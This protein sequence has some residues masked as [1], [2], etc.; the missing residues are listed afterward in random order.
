MRLIGIASCAVSRVDIENM[1]TPR[2][3]DRFA[4]LQECTRQASHP[5]CEEAVQIER[6]RVAQELKQFGRHKPSTATS[7]A[8]SQQR[9]TSLRTRPT[10]IRNSAASNEPLQYRDSIGSYATTQ[11]EVTRSAAGSVREKHWYSPI[12]KFWTDHV[13]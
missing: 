11:P 1:A 4:A 3:T 7:N 9:T 8:S 13:R 10:S 2:Y 5:D 12:V 6:Q